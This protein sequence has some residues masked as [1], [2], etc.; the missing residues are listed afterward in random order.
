M[1]SRRNRSNRGRDCR[2]CICHVG[3]PK[4][5]TRFTTPRLLAKV[6]GANEPPIRSVLNGRACCHTAL[7]RAVLASN[8]HSRHGSLLRAEEPNSLELHQGAVCCRILIFPRAKPMFRIL[9]VFSHLLS[10]SF[11]E[12]RAVD[13]ELKRCNHLLASFYTWLHLQQRGANP[14]VRFPPCWVQLLSTLCVRE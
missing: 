8:P 13:A 11:R 3:Q 5:I 6:Q 14:P 1:A 12:R 9:Q 10:L 7:T 4:P 2:I